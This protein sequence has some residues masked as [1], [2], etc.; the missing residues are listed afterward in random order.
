[1][2][3]RYINQSLREKNNT[4]IINRRTKAI[5]K[6]QLMLIQIPQK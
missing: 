3:S 4:I 5:M 1:M 2:G 6:N